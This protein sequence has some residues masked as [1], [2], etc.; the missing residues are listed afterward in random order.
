MIVSVNKFYRILII[1]LR[2]IYTALLSDWKFGLFW[3]TYRE[4]Y[5]TW[6]VSTEFIQF[7]DL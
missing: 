3:Q 7:T 1:L 2:V 6:Q 5:E 4:L